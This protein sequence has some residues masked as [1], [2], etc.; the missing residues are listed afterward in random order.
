ME[1]P[2]QEQLNELK[3]LSSD[4]GVADE[5]KL[6]PP[7]KTQK[8]LSRLEKRKRSSVELGAGVS[9]S[10]TGD[11][12]AMSIL[13]ELHHAEEEL[14][15]RA[16]ILMDGTAGSIEHVFSTMFMDSEYRLSGMAASG[17]SQRSRQSSLNVVL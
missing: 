3:R 7:K 14:L 16:V 17:L 6:A 1:M 12:R 9:A 2:T 4:A 15:G 8:R 11:Q 13:A 5:S 10:V